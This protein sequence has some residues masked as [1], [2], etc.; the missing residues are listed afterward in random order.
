MTA[1]VMLVD[2]GDNTGT[3]LLLAR[4]TGLEEGAFE[5]ALE[6]VVEGLAVEAMVAVLLVG[7][8]D[9][10]AVVAVIMESDCTREEG[11][12]VCARVGN[13]ELTDVGPIDGLDIGT[14][15][16]SFSID[17]VIFLWSSVVALSKTRSSVEGS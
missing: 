6:G 11:T 5:G 16:G 15:A 3:G 12:C 4:K 10:S 14:G 13:S 2:T 9:E 1:A 8:T 7:N 17:E